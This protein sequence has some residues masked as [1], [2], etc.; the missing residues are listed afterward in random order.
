MGI[1]IFVAFLLGWFFGQN[2]G[3]RIANKA[4]KQAEFWEWK[5]GDL[6]ETI[7]RRTDQNRE[8]L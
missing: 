5:W 2:R 6:V 1:F 7:C 8:K 4:K 3:S